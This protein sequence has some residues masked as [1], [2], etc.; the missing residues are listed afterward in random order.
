MQKNIM[1]ETF[2]SRY[3]VDNVPLFLG[4]IFFLYSYGTAILLFITSL[5]L[6]MT[7]KVVITG[8]E[9]LSEHTNHIFC[10]WHSLVPLALQSVTPNI[11]AV[12]DRCPQAWMQHPIWFMK[13]IHVLLRLM[14]VEKLI[15]GSTGHSGREAAEELVEYLRQGYSTVLNPDGPHGPAFVLKKGVLHV[16][17]QSGVPVVAIQFNASHF[18]ELKTWDRKKVPYPFSTI[19]MKLAPPIQITPFNFDGADSMIERALG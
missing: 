14:G 11:P 16:S 7:I 2:L 18:F 15:M 19:K 8:R 5:V 13:P 9:N 4:P 10:L 1:G 6:K 3:R 12:L 17:L